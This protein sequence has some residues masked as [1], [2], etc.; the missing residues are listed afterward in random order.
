MSKKLLIDAKDI[1]ILNILQKE[2]AISNKDLSGKVGLSPP[3]TLKRVSDLVSKGFIKFIVGI[4]NLKKFG[5]RFTTAVEYSVSQ[6]NAEEFIN[7]VVHQSVNLILFFETRRDVGL[8]TKYSTFLAVYT[9]KD[10][11]H[12]L[13]KM[14]AIIGTIPF[15]IDYRIYEVTR[16]I[17]SLPTIELSLD[18]LVN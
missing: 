11:R 1:R 14:K 13:E 12:F 15:H 4:V 9:H 17:K 2:G 3:P 7:L 5:Y 6:D 18:D 16:M 8:G 10:Q